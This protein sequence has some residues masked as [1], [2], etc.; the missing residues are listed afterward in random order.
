MCVGKQEYSGARGAIVSPIA[1]FSADGCFFETFDCR[2][3][4]YADMRQKVKGWPAVMGERARVL[5][6]ITEASTRRRASRL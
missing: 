4:A 5:I 6:H 2:C 3:P 1:L